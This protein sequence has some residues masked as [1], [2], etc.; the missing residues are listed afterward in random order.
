MIQII[1]CRQSVLET[2]SLRKRRRQDE[3]FLVRCNGAAEYLLGNR[4]SSESVRGARRCAMKP[5]N[6]VI[7]M[8]K[9]GGELS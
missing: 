3:A 2:Q 5:G 9:R 7:E 6:N 8:V 4:C 1:N